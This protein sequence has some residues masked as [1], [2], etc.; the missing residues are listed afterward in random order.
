MKWLFSKMYYLFLI[1]RVLFDLVHRIPDKWISDEGFESGI[2]DALFEILLSKRSKKQR[3]ILNDVMKELLL[4]GSSMSATLSRSLFRLILVIWIRNRFVGSCVQRESSIDPKATRQVMKA[5]STHSFTSTSSLATVL[6]LFEF[7][8]D[9]LYPELGSH[10]ENVVSSFL[11]LTKDAKESVFLENCECSNCIGKSKHRSVYRIH[12]SQQREAMMSTW[13]NCIR[14]VN[15]LHAEKII[16][17]YLKYTLASVTSQ[18]H[19]RISLVTVEMIHSCCYALGTNTLLDVIESLWN[20]PHS[21]KHLSLLSSLIAHSPLLDL[22]SILHILGMITEEMAPSKSSLLLI[23]HCILIQGSHASTPLD[24]VSLTMLHRLLTWC[25]TVEQT[26]WRQIPYRLRWCCGSEIHR[27]SP[28]TVLCCSRWCLHLCPICSQSSFALLDTH[29][30]LCCAS[31]SHSLSFNYY[32][33]HPYSSACSWQPPQSTHDCPACHRD[34][35]T[36][37]HSCL[38]KKGFY[39]RCYD[40]STSNSSEDSEAPLAKRH[41][42]EE[43][44]RVFTESHQAV[45][46]FSHIGSDVLLHTMQ[47]LT[48]RD[49]LSTSACSKELLTLGTHEWIWKSRYRNLFVDYQCNH[50]NKY[51]HN[52]LALFKRRFCILKRLKENEQICQF[53][54]CNRHFKQLAAFLEHVAR[55]HGSCVCSLRNNIAIFPVYWSM[56]NTRFISKNRSFNLRHLRTSNWTRIVHVVSDSQK[57][58]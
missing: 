1:Q 12:P 34:C 21:L 6:S 52:Y 44:E 20:Q 8:P 17:E 37:S 26:L 24:V 33:P 47:Y 45:L 27:L 36:S 31:T 10:L 25:D 14:G 49:L 42:I 54:G 43:I 23:L 51:K 2:V 19:F 46:A 40:Y 30:V 18:Q 15:I 22:K 29:C 38:C 11:I 32:V 57:L 13:N 50:S 3:I 16:K 28:T 5:L 48:V 4:C 7:L 56:C 53:C 55:D 39:T 9:S 58:L 35:S 41:R